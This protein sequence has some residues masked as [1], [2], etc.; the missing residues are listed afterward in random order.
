MHGSFRVRNETAFFDNCSDLFIYDKSKT[1][2][3][4]FASFATTII[5]TAIVHGLLMKGSYFVYHTP[6]RARL[7]RQKW[8]KW[9]LQTL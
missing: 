1:D 9:K 4:C 8:Q 2:I 5:K 3:W 7:D 6:L